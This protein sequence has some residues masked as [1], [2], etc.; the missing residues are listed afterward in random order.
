M[1]LAL[2]VMTFDLSITANIKQATGQCSVVLLN[3]ITLK[4]N[5]LTQIGYRRQKLS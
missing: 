5:I 3:D 4:N 2:N 1:V